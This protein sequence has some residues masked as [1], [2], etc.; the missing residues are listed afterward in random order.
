MKKVQKFSWGEITWLKVSDSKDYCS[1]GI[2]KILPGKKIKKHIHFGDN[3]IYYITKG[4]GYQW[5]NDKRT[6]VEPGMSFNIRVGEIHE[7]ENS[8]EEVLEG[9]VVSTSN[10]QDFSKVLQ[11]STPAKNIFPLDLPGLS[12]DKEILKLHREIMKK[13]CIPVSLF[14]K[15]G[16][17]L[18]KGRDF[19]TAC[20]D[21]CRIHENIENCPFYTNKSSLNEHND[22]IFADVCEF[23]III[24]NTPVKYLNKIV[25]HIKAGHI[26]DY[27]YRSESSLNIP[28]SRINATIF[29]LRKFTEEILNYHVLKSQIHDNYN[30]SLLVKELSEEKMQLKEDNKVHRE[31]LLST[32]LTS[33]FLYNTLNTIA[34]LALKENAETTYAS[35]LN[36]SKL[37]RYG[38]TSNLQYA[39]LEE[40]LDYLHSYIS[41]A[42]F[43]TSGKIVFKWETDKGLSDYHI[44][45][46]MLQPIIEN[47]LLHG[48]K[49]NTEAGIFTIKIFAKK[50]KGKQVKIT[51]CDSGAGIASE[52][53][54]A[55]NRML[56]SDTTDYE[57]SL[58]G[59]NG[60]K[61]LKARLN[62]YYNEDYSLK[63]TSDTGKGTVC[64]I[65]LPSDEG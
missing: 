55:I 7:I 33:H 34:S 1:V 6:Y 40:E 36:L 50:I 32:N 58:S 8:A 19:P 56:N 23:G 52:K 46:G 30:K 25:G 2:V 4:Q 47:S 41:L 64:E 12:K 10:L 45:Q 42:Q 62:F 11:K 48:Y 27:T 14:D 35:I 60:L 38:K 16:N 18:L 13:L 54:S 9:I 26:T 15:Y 65:L 17:L 28:K 43:E 37:L 63:L 57:F 49:K 3:Q 5:I 39:K 31:T 59:H 53:L 22:T 24:L 20:K 44:P 61:M 29:S 21:N 51:I